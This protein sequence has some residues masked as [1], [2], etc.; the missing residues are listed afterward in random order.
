[1]KQGPP[2][3][4]SNRTKTG[5]RLWQAG[6][7]VL[8]IIMILFV[9]KLSSQPP[10]FHVFTRTGHKGFVIGQEK[11]LVLD[12]INTHKTIRAIRTCHPES[13]TRL[14]SRRGFDMSPDLNAS[15]L[16]I[17]GDRKKGGYVFIFRDARLTMLVYFTGRADKVPDLFGACRQDVHGDLMQYLSRQ[18]GFP[19]RYEQTSP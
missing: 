3:S 9:E 1:M 13:H 17:C 14:S 19:V 10:E 8:I 16:W 7:A 6:F 18:A 4:S 15:R 2:D 5:Q 11:A 12:R